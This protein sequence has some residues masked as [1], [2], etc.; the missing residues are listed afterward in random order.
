MMNDM[1]DMI[2]SWHHAQ[3]CKKGPPTSI[4]TI[5]NY[6]N[7]KANIQQTSDSCQ[8]F[9]CHYIFLTCYDSTKMIC[10]ILLRL[11]RYVST[12]MLSSERFRTHATN[13]VHSKN[14]FK[15]E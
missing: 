13:S 10:S 14:T 12:E 9:L 2:N 8:I 1:K 7:F 5:I 4:Y 3:V 11:M 6:P 15:I